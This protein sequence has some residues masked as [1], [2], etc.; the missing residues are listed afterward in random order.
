MCDAPFDGEAVARLA[1]DYGSDLAALKIKLDELE[2]R[3]K[4]LKLPNTYASML[5]TLRGHL[6]RVRA[7][8]TTRSDQRPQRREARFSAFT[9]TA[10]FAVGRRV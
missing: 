9:E 4:C 5:Y 2:K 8:L 1:R 3:A 6:D 7:R 10:I